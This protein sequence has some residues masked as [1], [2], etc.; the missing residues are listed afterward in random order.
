M[1]VSAAQTSIVKLTGFADATFH[2]KK[3]TGLIL[4]QPVTMLVSVE[5]TPYMEEMLI[6]TRFQ[7]ICAGLR[8]SH[9][10]PHHY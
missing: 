3:A 1:V 10:T 5:L 4:I 2:K 9:F 7:H 8:F 6:E